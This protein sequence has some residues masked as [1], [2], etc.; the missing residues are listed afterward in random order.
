MKII[1]LII[2]KE[3]EQIENISHLKQLEDLNISGN[4]I[5]YIKNSLAENANLKVVLF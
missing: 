2:I 3:I 4:K 5:K 1:I